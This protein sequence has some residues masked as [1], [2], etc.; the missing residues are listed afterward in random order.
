MSSGAGS[1]GSAA[2]SDAERRVIETKLAAARTRLILDK[3]FLGALVLRLPMHASNPEWCPTTATDARAFYY[4]PEYI[5]SLSLDQTQFMLA[6][7]ALHCALSHFARRQHRIK[8]K[9]DLAC[10]YAI[11]PLLIDEGLTPPPNA[12]VMPPYKG[13]TAEE[14]YPLIDDNDESETLDTHAYDRD[15]RQGGSRSGMSE[16]DLDRQPEQPQSQQ[17]ESEEG[18][19]ANRSAQPDQSGGPDS[20]LGQSQPEPNP[21]T[22]DEQET[23]SVQWQQRLAGAAQ[24]AQQAGKLGREMARMIDHLL[25][26]RLPWRMLLARYMTAV[27]REDYSYARPSRRAGDFIRPSL[28]AQQTDLVVAVDTSGSIQAAELEEFIG[29]IDALKGQ[30]RARVTLLPCDAALCEGAP[31]RFEPWES[32]RLPETIRGGGG[33]SFRPV[34]QWIDREGLRPDLLV[35]FTDAQGEFPPVE[36]SF[37]VIWLVKGRGKVPW[38]QRIQLN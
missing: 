30:V 3:P 28:R 17:G 34:F 18:Q 33:T 8:H 27:S 32:F 20:G 36:P 23:L 15:S 7:E 22:P 12:L 26:P 6:H 14:I 11:N 9:W 4:N 5:A 1:A 31:F 24:Q 19:G 29:E 25:Q 21:L 38:G 35:Y 10:D 16:K 13:M 2:V 37:P